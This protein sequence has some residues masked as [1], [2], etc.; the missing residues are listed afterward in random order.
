MTVDAIIAFDVD[1]LYRG[2]VASPER[3]HDLLQA[4]GGKFLA[5]F[6]GNPA[7]ERKLQE[8][9]ARWDDPVTLRYELEKMARASYQSSDELRAAASHAAQGVGLEAHV[10]AVFADVFSILDAN[11][12]FVRLVDDPVTRDGYL[13]AYLVLFPTQ[14]VYLEHLRGN[15]DSIL[16]TGSAL[17]VALGRAGHEELSHLVQEL[18][19]S[20]LD[21]K[22]EYLS[23]QK[24]ATSQL[25]KDVWG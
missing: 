7:A 19:V 9:L 22:S 3:R 18:V 12:E 2:L 14:N 16:S 23:I 17:S 25:R 6:H 1:Y 4:I 13:H 5:K 24:L 11:Q 20:V 15:Y 21:V 10:D 8:D